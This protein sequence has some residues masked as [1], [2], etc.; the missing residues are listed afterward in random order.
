MFD[1]SLSLITWRSVVL[2]LISLSVSL[3]L[4]DYLEVCCSRFDLSLSL[5]TWRS[6]VLGLISLSLSDY[7]E[8]CC[9]MFDL[10]L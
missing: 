3:S 2:C 1:L 5:I 6:V 9:S 4:S 7:L 10:S 8:V